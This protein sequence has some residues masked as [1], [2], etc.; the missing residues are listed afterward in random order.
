MC[1]IQFTSVPVSLIEL[2]FPST[3][4]SVDEANSKEETKGSCGKAG[5]NG[6]FER[7]TDKKY[8]VNCW[9][10][11]VNYPEDTDSSGI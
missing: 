4:Q 11:G 8:G 9:R 1:V 6:M 5:L 10:E 7:D 2:I 3:Q